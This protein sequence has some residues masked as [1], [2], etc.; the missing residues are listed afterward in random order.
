MGS[1][2]IVSTKPS[3][4]SPKDGFSTFDRKIDRKY[5]DILNLVNLSPDNMPDNNNYTLA[6][7]FPKKNRKPSKRWYIKFSAYNSDSN[8]LE[9]KILWIPSSLKDVKSRNEW[10]NERIR[11]INEALVRGHIFISRKSVKTQVIIG[12]TLS[13]ELIDAL[14][15]ALKIKKVEA[16]NIF[17]KNVE[18]RGK[19][20][21]KNTSRT[22]NSCKVL[23]N[24]WL[25][26]ENLDLTLQD[27]IYD[28][29]GELIQSYVYSFRDYLLLIRGN[30]NQ[31]ANNQIRLLNGLLNELKKRNIIKDNPASK[32]GKLKVSIGKNL[33]FSQKEKA[34]LIETIKKEDKELYLF[35]C[36]VYYTMIRPN[37]VRFL[38][39]K[40]I[41]ND[42]VYI[43]EL[44]A[45]NNISE[46]V[47]IPE[48]FQKILKEFS[49][50]DYP[51]ERFV[52]HYPSSPKGTSTFYPENHFY[53]RFKSYLKRLNMMEHTL[54]SW[55]HT[56][57]IDAHN[58]NIPIDF[59]RQQL[60][61]KSL[62]TTMIYLK[63]LGVMTNIAIKEKFPEL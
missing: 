42:K 6:E 22:Y 47:V 62:E 35:I 39:V 20:K 14:E 56:A 4:G 29:N 9:E 43:D 10:A 23:I 31:T 49:I 60:R 11:L 59:I 55:R 27:F 48:H 45:K 52:F 1:N 38:K 46:Y 54:Y 28:S 53:N 63:S 8:S 61:H 16:E 17:S 19:V 12:I 13:S 44:L 32:I 37:E 50:R 21:G 25:L 51:K 3:L 33:A 34:I 41:M 40:D 24:D 30:S 58:A 7:L 15:Y 2:P 5:T 26:N 18:E 36:F 57:A